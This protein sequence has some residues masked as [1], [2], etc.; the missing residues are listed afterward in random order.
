MRKP[1]VPPPQPLRPP[2]Q[3]Q[4]APSKGGLFKGLFKYVTNSELISNSQVTNQINL[5]LPTGRV[6]RLPSLP[7]PFPLRSVLHSMQYTQHICYPVTYH[8]VQGWAKRCF[9]GC[10]N[11]LPGSAW[12]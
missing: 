2:G 6:V 11:S 12:L 5:F 4:Q 3:P 9:L 7:R 8:A 10:V 1:T